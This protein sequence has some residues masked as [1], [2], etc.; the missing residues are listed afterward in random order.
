MFYLT[1]VKKHITLQ[2]AKSVGGIPVGR[3]FLVL[4][5]PK[6]RRVYVYPEEASAYEGVAY[7]HV[8]WR[9]GGFAI[10]GLPT[11]AVFVGQNPLPRE[12]HEWLAEHLE[13]VLVPAWIKLCE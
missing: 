5:H 13:S 1:Y 9:G 12:I 4:E 6:G 11:L 8:T 3:A 2:G 10:V 7:C